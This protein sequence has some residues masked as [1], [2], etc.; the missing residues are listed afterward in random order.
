MK[1]YL[2][3]QWLYIK[4]P[5][6]RVS[7]EH[8]ALRTTTV[9][10]KLALNE[11]LVESKFISVDPYM[12]IQQS[13]NP[14]WEQ[15]HPLN[16]VQ[17]AAVVGRVLDTKSGDFAVGDWVSGYLGWQSHAQVHASELQRL[18][19]EQVDVTTALGVL[20]MPGRTAW[21]G[22]MEAGKPVAGETVVVS[23]AAGAVG[24]LVTQFAIKSGCRVIAIAGSEAKCHWLRTMGASYALNY[25]HYNDAVTLQKK[26]I[27][28]GGVDVY[29]DNV[30][31]M[32]SDAVLSSLNLRARIVI[33]G[34]ISQYDGCLDTPSLG[35]RFLHQLLYKRATIQ[36]IL[37]RDY[38]HRM[39][40]LTERLLPWIKAGE[41]EFKTTQ[42]EG[43]ENLP[44]ALAGLFEGHN[45]G[46]TIV[47]VTG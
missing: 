21:Y 8:Y 41:I 17:G 29:F 13:K 14:T 10:S 16:T 2:L 3:K 19:S 45:T 40:E 36:G 1:T 37:A 46:K 23:G 44:R 27:E 9:T 32:I 34:Q 5:T 6:G 25:T 11:V 26:L 38:T 43:F 30:G 7:D 42:I 22:L 47:K 18:D 20:G 15:P 28:L 35:P 24:S 31:G 4:R 33:C 39:P 12:R